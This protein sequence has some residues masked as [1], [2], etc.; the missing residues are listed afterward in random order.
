MKNEKVYITCVFQFSESESSQNFIA[1][2]V[3]SRL[4]QN[5]VA[6]NSYLSSLNSISSSSSPLVSIKPVRAQAVSV[7]EK[8]GIE[9][10]GGETNP[11]PCF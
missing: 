6:S 7:R 9:K 10:T 3:E 1:L 4:K 8:S 11:K 5:Y 2:S